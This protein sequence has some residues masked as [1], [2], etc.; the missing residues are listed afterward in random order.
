MSEALERLAAL[1]TVM[2]NPQAADADVKQAQQL[3]EECY[4]DPGTIFLLF[5][6]FLTNPTPVVQLSSVV[7][8]GRILSK[9][10]AWVVYRDS[11]RGE[12][13]KQMF[14][15][16][17]RQTTNV[18]FFE[19]LVFGASHIL[20]V[21]CMT[22]PQYF[23]LFGQL[24]SGEGTTQR[25][26]IM[27]NSALPHLSEDAVANLWASV[28]AFAM[29][30][31]KTQNP[32]L[33]VLASH[34]VAQ[35]F[36]WWEV[37]SDGLAEL[38]GAVIESLPPLMSSENSGALKVID[39]LGSIGE[40][41][42]EIDHVAILKR[43]VEMA[44][45]PEFAIDHRVMLFEAIAKYFEKTAVVPESIGFVI[46]AAIAVG[47][48]A[49]D[50][51]L[52]YRDQENM[53]IVMN[54]FEVIM[55]IADHDEVYEHVKQKAAVAEPPMIVVF[56]K[57][58]DEI[59][60]KCPP[61]YQKDV[62]TLLTYAIT[63][64]HTE[65]HTVQEAGFKLMSRMFSRG[66]DV[67]YEKMQ[68]I[69]SEIFNAL[70]IQHVPLIEY[71]LTCLYKFLAVVPLNSETATSVFQAIAQVLKAY[72]KALQSRVIDCFTSLARSAR[73]DIQAVVGELVPLVSPAL[74]LVAAEDVRIRASAVECMSVI[75]RFSQP[76]SAAVTAFLQKC[77][78]GLQSGDDVLMASGMAGISEL[79]IV[80]RPEIAPAIDGI[81]RLVH[82]I[83]SKEP[84]FEDDEDKQEKNDLMEAV[85]N[86]TL[87]L[88]TMLA[89]YL[90]EV[91]AGAIP[92]L[93]AD[94]YRLIEKSVN[95]I[96]K[97]AVRA[98]THLTVADPQD[99]ENFAKVLIE[100]LDS[101]SPEFAAECFHCFG[102][103]MEKIAAPAPVVEAAAVC[104]MQFMTRTL[105][106][107]LADEDSSNYD[108]DLGAEVYYVL[109]T[110][111]SKYPQAFPIDDFMN[112]MQKT[113]KKGAPVE[114]AEAIGA[115]TYYFSAAHE[116]MKSLYK[117][118]VVR[119]FV[120][121]LSICDFYV[122]PEPIAGVRAVAETEPELIAGYLPD[123]FKYIDD[124]FGQEYQGELCFNMTMDY[125]VSLLFTLFRAVLKDK[126][127][128]AK[129]IP[130]M[131]S[132]LPTTS[133]C[134]SEAANIYF[135]LCFVCSEY[136]Q[137]MGQFGVEVVRILAQMLSCKEK[138]WVDIS[139][140]T[141]IASACAVLFNNLVNS[142]AQGKDIV[143][144]SCGNEIAVQRLTTRLAALSQPNP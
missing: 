49:F 70:K 16:A 76:E 107:S 87:N 110:I 14:L 137:V 64:V 22:W 51:E 130:K 45:H 48:Q 40:T 123:I 114:I 25:A 122:P 13:L 124:A 21:D 3:L 52:C 60:R 97:P 66:N 30:V 94:V 98:L 74:D 82:E 131:L 35:L 106:C 1:Y 4:G 140:P 142:M 9:Q 55:E 24:A 39:D 92:G 103:Y 126:F 111:G 59:I 135:S 109:K 77:I 105:E 90:P 19:N 128:V 88:V 144:A 138:D 33:V 93:K 71:V 136:P 63:C 18:L 116:Q 23:E 132:F 129:Y 120:Q 139:L 81:I 61:S 56:V 113:C 31:L 79:V 68:E 99:S 101:F 47:L 143:S 96:M 43:L 102:T 125:I 86:Y 50:P 83:M 57:A 78:E 62:T 72:P 73:E 75:F 6:L 8:I 119:L 15:E 17:M 10:N 42:M 117:K 58:M 65:H 67:F 108:M 2:A 112:Q 127:D 53:N 91:I 36:N 80:R 85:W 38:L 11:G 54:V 104:A 5:Q 26:L 69:L 28:C 12:E 133:S 84:S 7:G 37:K 32:D 29:S 20:K 118:A 27:I 121:E 100:N 95:E 44:V 89:K 134:P 41:T 115:L 46:E 141:E 34:V